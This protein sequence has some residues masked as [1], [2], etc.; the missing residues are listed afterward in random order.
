MVS[1]V[2]FQGWD[3]GTLGNTLSGCVTQDLVPQEASTIHPTHTNVCVCGC[4]HIYSPRSVVSLVRL[5]R[6]ASESLASNYTL[7]IA[8]TALLCGCSVV[9]LLFSPD[10][11]LTVASMD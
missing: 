3:V 7:G 11:I 1:G 5:S 6:G 8:V 10:C 4:G 9:K 2:L